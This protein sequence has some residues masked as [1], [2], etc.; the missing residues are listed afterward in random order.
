M[1]STI[2]FQA[3]RCESSFL[4]PRKGFAPTIE[5]FEVRT[6][7]LTGRTGHF[8]HFGAVKTQPLALDT[9]RESKV[10]G[11]CP[12]CVQNREKYTPKF[13]ADVVPE[14][15][16]LKNEA[17][18]IPNLFPYDIHG[19]VLVMTDEH[20]VSLGELSERRLYDAF[21]LGMEFLRR[22]TSVEPSPA[23]HVMTWNYM[24]PSGGGLV[25]PHQQYF[26]TDFPGNQFMDELLGSERFFGLH[27]INFWSQLVKEE[28]TGDR[29][30]GRTGRAHWLTPF[31]SFGLLGDI[32]AVFPDVTSVSDF[33]DFHISELVAGLLKVFHYFASAGIGS[34]NASLFFGPEN[35]DYFS[36]HFRIVPRTF[37]N[38]R[39]FASDFNFFQAMLAEP[40]SL[41]MPEDLCLDLRA[42]FSG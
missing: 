11:F 3:V 42:Y 1:G 2:K 26:A 15:R 20:V 29:Y 35:Q 27:G 24:P 4:D 25:H 9:Y 12:F 13:S 33:R 39:D 21:S 5:I 14:G 28:A 34:F 36:S 18:L 23:Y 31:V 32:M 19:S 37:L 16:L 30:V 41:V 8:S 10:M 38:M 7:P 6:D 17:F 22:T 40:V